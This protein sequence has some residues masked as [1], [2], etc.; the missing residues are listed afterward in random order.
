[1]AVDGNWR[2]IISNGFK[3]FHLSSAASEI[4][5]RG[6]LL[7][8][9]NGLYPKLWIR[10]CF[11]LVGLGKHGR[12][13][14]LLG[15]GVEID[16][17]RVRM[18]VFEDVLN[19][20]GLFVERIHFM[21]KLGSRITAFSMRQFAVKARMVLKEYETGPYIYHYRSGFGLTSLTEAR[22]SGAILLCDHSIAHPLVID[23]LINNAGAM[24]ASTERSK[25]DPLWELVLRDIEDADH[26]VVNSEF[27]KSTFEHLGFPSEK[28]SVIYLG[29]D[30][31]FLQSVP[32][33]SERN[34]REPLRLFFAGSF[35]DRKGARILLEAISHL[36]RTGW[37][38]CLAGTIEPHLKMA[39]EFLESEYPVKHL[40]NL[41]R[42]QLAQ[43]MSASDV[44]VFPSLAEGSAR[45]IF[46]AMA[47]GC[48]IITTPNAGSIVENGVHGL[49]VPPGD[50]A[51]LSQ[52]LK[53]TME[54]SAVSDVGVANAKLIYKF[55]RQ[56][57]YGEKL[58]ALY[59][60]LRQ[61]NS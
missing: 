14:K 16:D 23:G 41:T 18:F 26:V 10:K 52:A 17:E 31:V 8:L 35:S 49:L 50:V 27:V 55:Y 48:F 38:L 34:C 59:E 20:F 32:K 43:A 33:R 6:A 36:P 54:D 47:C 30:D 24:V 19:D 53:V 45:V 44:F 2:V 51:A 42:E 29:V 40:G 1:M 28:L 37:T 21:G 4:D 57:F 60:K 5:K 11:A 9:F 61:I 58:V 46:E 12:L 7:A 15:R 13:A 22:R 39:V 3:N 25:I 56:Q